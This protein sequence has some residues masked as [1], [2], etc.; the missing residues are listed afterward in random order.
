LQLWKEA[1][2]KNFYKSLDHR[3]FHFK[4]HEKKSLSNKAYINEIKTIAN[5]SLRLKNT[6]Q[7]KGG[8]K[9]SEFYCTYST[10]EPIC[11][12]SEAS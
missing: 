5:Q 8:S 10:F 9:D 11:V 7:L 4:F 6:N 3:S 12:H 2:E 1:S